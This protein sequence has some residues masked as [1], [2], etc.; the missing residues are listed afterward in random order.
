VGGCVSTS[1]PNKVKKAKKKLEKHAKGITNIIKEHPELSD[2]FTI[3]K[4]DTIYIDNHIIDTTYKHVYDT[5]KVDSILMQYVPVEVVRTIRKTIEKEILK[6]TTLTYEDSLIVAYFGFKNQNHFISIEVKEQKH[7]YI[8]ETHT[9]K[10]DCQTKH[11]F[12]RD[13]RFWILFFILIYLYA[14]RK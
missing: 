6:D 12:W 2:T 9:T 11:Q 10:F 3:I 8:S 7:A 4:H 14:R 13:W 5:I 1:A